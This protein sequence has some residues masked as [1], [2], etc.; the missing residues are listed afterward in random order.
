MLT[1]DLYSS[2][3]YVY[4]M[5]SRKKILQKMK[6]FYDEIKNKRNKK[7]MRL[8]VDN[9]FQ[10]VKSKDLNYKNNVE[11]FTTYVRG[12]KAFAAKRKIRELKTRISKSNAQ[13]LK[14][15]P[16][17]IISSSADNMNSVQNEKCGLR[18]SLYQV[19][20]L[21]HYLIFIEQKEQN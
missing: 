11:M 4:P 8:Q 9:E 10:Q 17:K 14:I 3:I 18:K 6:Q 15:S 20:D 16:T 19:K 5:C 1:V 12:G 13:K 21:E 7:T 2:K